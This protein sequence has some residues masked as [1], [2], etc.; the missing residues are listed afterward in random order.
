MV[1]TAW[2]R[3]EQAGRRENR[4]ADLGQEE[5]TALKV[6]AGRVQIQQTYVGTPRCVVLFPALRRLP[7][8][9]RVE[10]YGISHSHF[11]EKRPFG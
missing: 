7:L 8:G 1:A 6:H 4:S 3:D 9:I 10:R 11:G 2:E 5:V